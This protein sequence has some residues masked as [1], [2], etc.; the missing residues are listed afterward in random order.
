[1]R[2]P[3]GRPW[4][5]ERVLA[6]LPLVLLTGALSGWVGWVF[7]G[8]LRA[9]AG[10][11]SPATEFG[12]RARARAAAVAALVLALVGLVATYQPQR[13]GPPMTVQ[14]L[15][16]A[17][18]PAF[19][20]TEAI[21]W[22]VFFADG[23]PFGSTVEARSEGIID[24]MPMPVGPAWCAPTEAALATA[25]PRVRFAME[26]NGAPVDLTPYPLVRFRLRAG[27]HCAWVGVA[28]A[29]QRASQNRFVYTIEHA[30]LGGP[31][32][33]RVDLLVTFKDP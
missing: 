9:V 29:F 14:E 32:R 13:Y 15:K 23:W 12:S 33:I 1:M 8:F 30:A 21:F 19:P 6:G 11:G 18:L 4:P 24:G 25:L 17:P 22:N 5:A 7:G 27:E 31:A 10:L 26:V 28:S 20:Y 3:V 16:F 2:W